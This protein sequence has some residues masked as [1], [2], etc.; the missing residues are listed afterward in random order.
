MRRP[1]KLE[2]GML[3][4]G[5]IATGIASATENI[6]QVTVTGYYYDPFAWDPSFANNYASSPTGGGGPAGVY[7]ANPTA[8]CN[9]VTGQLSQA[10]KQGG[11]STPFSAK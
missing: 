7:S 5:V 10:Q 9:C 1:S 4:G 2:L 6:P 11:N 3:V 8:H